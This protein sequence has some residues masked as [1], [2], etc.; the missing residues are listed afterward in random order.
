MLTTIVRRA[1][2][3]IALSGM[4]L[5]AQAP[6]HAGTDPLQPLHFL[7]GK[8]AAHGSGQGATTDGSYTFQRELGGHVLARHSRSTA[9]KAPADFDCEHGDLLYVYTDGPGQSLKAI[10]FDSE[11]HSIHY[12]VTTP[13]PSKALFLS[14]P[15]GG[16]PQFRL[17]Y[18]L[19]GGVMKGSFEMQMPGQAAWT[20]Y[21]TW[22]GGSQ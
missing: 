5:V 2:T 17:T 7:E 18:A 12:D 13:E 6:T 14:E 10:Y 11:G 21:L 19:S 1:L 4:A 8:W 16:G 15:S 22:S 3:G 20:P 9:C